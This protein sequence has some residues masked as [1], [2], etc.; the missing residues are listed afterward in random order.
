M[1]EKDDSFEYSV[2]NVFRLPIAIV[3]GGV[4]GGF[5][6]LPIVHKGLDASGPIVVS[7]G[8]N[9]KLT[10]RYVV[11]LGSVVVSLAISAI[12]SMAFLKL[13]WREKRSIEE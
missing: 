4:V 3:L 8:W 1:Y 5:A 6:F 12:I 10:A 2:W 9:V 13:V 7:H 11:V